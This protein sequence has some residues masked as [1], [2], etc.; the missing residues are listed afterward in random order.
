[1]IE[2]FGRSIENLK[3]SII[4][5]VPSRNKDVRTI[6]PR[7]GNR[8][9]L[10]I[11]MLKIWMKDKKA[12]SFACT[13]AHANIPQIN[14]PPPRNWQASKIEEGYTLQEKEKMHQI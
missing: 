1:M 12:R 7:K 9:L 13:M 14:I 3:K 11:L 8:S 6:D 10:T 5:S 4:P 2:F